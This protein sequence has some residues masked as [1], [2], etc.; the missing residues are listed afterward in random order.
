MGNTCSTDQSISVAQ[1]LK[2]RRDGNSVFPIDRQIAEV[3]YSDGK[4][5][6][7]LDQ[8]DS[9]DSANLGLIQ[10]LIAKNG[11]TSPGIPA[12]DL[13]LDPDYMHIPKTS[14]LGLLNQKAERSP[15]AIAR[16]NTM[17]LTHAA[18]GSAR[19]WE[20]RELSKKAAEL[21]LYVV[22]WNMNGR[23]PQKNLS[24]LLDLDREKHDLYVVGLQEAPKFSG[25][26]T[27]GKLLGDNYCCVGMSS[28]MSLQLYVFARKS[29]R[30]HITGTMVDKVPVGGLGYVVGRQKGAAAV[31]LAYNDMSLL[32]I[33]S[34]LA[35]KYF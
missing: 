19:Q 23:E 11:S 30:S 35:R 15:V 34:H 10:P 12:G 14:L 27:L 13:F 7:L 18:S 8:K 31:L 17:L 24:R 25:E 20:E 5:T 9:H 22:T 1:T 6:E 4:S 21:Q 29:L 16:G 3:Q 2:A 28:M 33:T 32:F 26:E